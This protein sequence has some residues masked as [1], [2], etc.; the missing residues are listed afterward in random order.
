M[1]DLPISR[2]QLFQPAFYHTGVDYFGPIEVRLFRRVVKRWGCLF[3]CMATGTIHLEMVYALDAD[4]FLCAYGNFKPTRG[5]PKVMLS[6]NGTN[7]KGAPRELAEALERLDSTKIHNRLAREG[8]EWIFN[9][10]AASHFCG[11]WERLMQSA[12]RALE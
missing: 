10:P 5:T 1:A 9:P 7:F 8:T 4:T 2:L 3:R 11:A 12:K 6:D